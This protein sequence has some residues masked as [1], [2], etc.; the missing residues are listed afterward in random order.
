MQDLLR[1]EKSGPKKNH[2]QKNIELDAS[3]HLNLC[4]NVVKR[5]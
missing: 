2:V 1:T 3:E 4:P 5:L